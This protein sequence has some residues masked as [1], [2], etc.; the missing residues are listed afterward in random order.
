VSTVLG[1][2]KRELLKDIMGIFGEQWCVNA[3]MSLT[4]LQTLARSKTLAKLGQDWQEMM[5][6]AQAE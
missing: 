3:P 1:I 4:N 6:K 5:K 2:P